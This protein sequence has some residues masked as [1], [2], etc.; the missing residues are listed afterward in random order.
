MSSSTG[1]PP[2]TQHP[3]RQQNRLVG[4]RSLLVTAGLALATGVAI[5]PSTTHA[6]T[7]SPSDSSA[8][9]TPAASTSAAPSQPQLE[10]TMG[11]VAHVDHDAV[12]LRFEDGQTET[13]IVGSTTTFQTQDGSAATLADLDVGDMAMIIT[14]EGSSTAA[15]I[16]D[17]GDTG[18]DA[19]G[20]YDIGGSEGT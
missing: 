5:V 2:V 11:T 16:V 7:T 9:T 17:A 10:F 18:F 19:G 13:Y 3:I 12:T 20:P 8:V 4:L 1:A 15:V 14:S 6:A